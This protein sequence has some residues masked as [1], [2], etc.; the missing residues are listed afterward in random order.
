M[1]TLAS[2]RAR[3][4]SG[5]ALAYRPRWYRHRRPRPCCRDITSEFSARP[6]VSPAPYRGSRVRSCTPARSSS[7]SASCQPA[8]S[9]FRTTDTSS[10]SFYSLSDNSRVP[11]R[12]P[13]SVWDL[14]AGEQVDP[15][16][17]RHHHPGHIGGPLG[18]A[19]RVHL[20]VDDHVVSRTDLAGTRSAWSYNCR[21]DSLLPPLSLTSRVPHR[22]PT[23]RPI[24]AF[25][26]LFREC[27]FRPNGRIAV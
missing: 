7:N 14:T 8:S 5:H 15:V 13:H 19:Y 25:S 27:A 16:G 18:V 9:S 22:R 11:R 17:E 23:K 24:L 2:D 26:G 3:P 12:F 6:S 1:P 4:E 10:M 21:R 20:L